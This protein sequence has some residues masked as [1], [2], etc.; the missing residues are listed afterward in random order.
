MSSKEKYSKERI[1]LRSGSTNDSFKSSYE[2]HK[3]KQIRRDEVREKARA[4]GTKLREIVTYQVRTEAK[5]RY[6]N[7]MPERPKKRQR[8]SFLGNLRL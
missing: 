5:E 8:I 4:K 7:R 3:R 1:T 6:F 2:E